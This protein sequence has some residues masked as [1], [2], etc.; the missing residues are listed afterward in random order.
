MSLPKFMFDADA[1]T[2]DTPHLTVEEHGAYLLL[3]LA[4]YRSE[5]PLPAS[6]RALAS[7]C[8]MTQDQWLICKP[9]LAPFFTEVDGVWRHDR[10]DTEIKRRNEEVA[11]YRT[12]ASNAVNSRWERQRQKKNAPSIHQVDQ[13]HT[14]LEL[15]LNSLSSAREGFEGKVVEDHAETV[16][17]APDEPDPPPRPSLTAINRN[18]QPPPELA[19]E[20]LAYTDASSY[21]LELQK[22]IYHH[23]ERGSLSENWEASFRLWMARFKEF[24]EKAAAKR[25]KPRVVLNPEPEPEHQINWDWHLSRWLNNESTWRRAT[26][27]PEPGQPGC[28]V[29]PDMFEKHGI[30]PATGRRKQKEPT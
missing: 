25:G 16:P 9:T 22:F 21:H 26:A 17:A 23:T 19:A 29:P 12:R 30:D 8:K 2:G 13:N 10:C 11:K 18:Y 15:E 27:G 5:K 4:Y 7:I 3:M 28:R 6:D 14:E 24:S 1:Y 20:I